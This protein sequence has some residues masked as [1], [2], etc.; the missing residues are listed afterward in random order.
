MKVAFRLKL[1]NRLACKEQLLTKSPNLRAR[2][3]S[4]EMACLLALR[5]IDCGIQN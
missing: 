2:N 1:R 5:N 3:P 4:Y